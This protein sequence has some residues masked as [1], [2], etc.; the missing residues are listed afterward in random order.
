MRGRG[1]HPAVSWRALGKRRT[2]RAMERRTALGRE[3][4]VDAEHPVRPQAR[5]RLLHL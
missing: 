5:R 1:V 2:Q 3:S 4:A